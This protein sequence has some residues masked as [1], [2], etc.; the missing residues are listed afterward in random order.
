[1]RQGQGSQPPEQGDPPL[2]QKAL[3]LQHEHDRGATGGAPGGH[4]RA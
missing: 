1:V 4:R 2:A 3:R